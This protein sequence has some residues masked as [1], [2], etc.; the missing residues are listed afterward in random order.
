MSIRYERRP[1]LSNQDL[2]DLLESDVPEEDR[3]DYSQILARS[4][5]WI[6]AYD[7][8]RLVG[9]CNVA[10]DGGVHAFLLDPTVRAGYRRRGIGTGLVREALAA[11]AEYPQLQWVH[12]DALPELMHG[13]YE[14]TGFR[15]TTAGLVWL[16]DLRSG[17]LHSGMRRSEPDQNRPT[18]G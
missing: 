7:G 10:W 5:L 8:H 6:G 2:G 17:A 13:F 16:D 3:A 18:T 4:L 15:P 11:T 1:A 12:V 14:P 9:Y